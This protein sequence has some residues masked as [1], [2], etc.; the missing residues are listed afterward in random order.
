MLDR[1]GGQTFL[2]LLSPAGPLL[3]TILDFVAHRRT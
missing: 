2:S 1:G 3:V